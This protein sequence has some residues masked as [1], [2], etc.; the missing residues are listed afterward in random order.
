MVKPLF[1]FL[2]WILFSLRSRLR[3][4][5][6]VLVKTTSPVFGKLMVPF[7]SMSGVVFSG[8]KG[9]PDMSCYVIFASNSVMLRLKATSKFSSSVLFRPPQRILVKEL[10]IN[11][12]TPAPEYNQVSVR[13]AFWAWRKS[14]GPL[15]LRTRHR[16]RVSYIGASPTGTVLL[17]NYRRYSFLHNKH[18]PCQ[19]GKRLKFAI[20]CL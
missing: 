13:P 6:S 15:H 14:G 19:V 11:A 9:L 12:R 2:G 5:S 1:L 10:V 18:K 17:L 3:T 20:E 4:L 7:R 16:S 8:G